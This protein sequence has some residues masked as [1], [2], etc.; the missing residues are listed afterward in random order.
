MNKQALINRLSRNGNEEEA[1]E[2][3][4]SLTVNDIIDLQI[5]LLGDF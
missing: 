2:F 3:L 4:E 5:E 1:N